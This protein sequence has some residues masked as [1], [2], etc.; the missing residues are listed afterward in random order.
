MPHKMS[1]SQ[2]DKCCQI[3]SSEVSKTVKIIES[4]CRMGLPGVEES[5][6]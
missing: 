2:K 6:K 5:E 4:N 1:Q 3:I